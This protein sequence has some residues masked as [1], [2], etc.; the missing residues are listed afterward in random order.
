MKL[1]MLQRE[2]GRQSRFYALSR[3]P[4]LTKNSF[5]RKLCVCPTHGSSV[6]KLDTHPRPKQFG[7]TLV[8]VVIAAAVL[9]IMIA[10][11]LNSFGYGFMASQ[12]AR[13]NQ[14]ATQV[15]LEKVET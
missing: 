3:Q 8:E 5:Q 6:S 1:L 15:M 7:A 9:T 10:G 12:L 2:A 13:E 14:R 11:V 4:D